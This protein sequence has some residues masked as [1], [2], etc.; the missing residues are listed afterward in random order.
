MRHVRQ[1]LV[2]TLALALLAATCTQP[3]DDTSAD[4]S[5]DSVLVDL[6]GIDHLKDEFNSTEPVPRLILPLSPT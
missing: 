5:Q 2:A 1:A 4:R 3:T 6:V